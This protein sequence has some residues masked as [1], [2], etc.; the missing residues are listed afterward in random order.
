[1]KWNRYHIAYVLLA[2]L[3]V[4]ATASTPRGESAKGAAAVRNML[5]AIDVNHGGVCGT[6]TDSMRIQVV[7]VG[8]PTVPYL[9]AALKSNRREYNSSVTGDL[10]IICMRYFGGPHDEVVAQAEAWWRAHR[11]ETEQEWILEALGSGENGRMRRAQGRADRLSD[12]KSMASLEALLKSDNDSVVMSALQVLW[13]NLASDKVLEYVHSALQNGT[14][15]QRIIA[16]RFCPAEKAAE[17]SPEVARV[18]RTETDPEVLAAALGAAAAIGGRDCI[19]IVDQ[20]NAQPTSNA[21]TP[22]VIRAM[23]AFHGEEY[24]DSVLYYLKSPVAEEREAAVQVFSDCVPPAKAITPLLAMLNERPGRRVCSDAGRTFLALEAAACDP[25]ARPRLAE[26]IVKLIELTGI[27]DES[28]IGGLAGSAL[29]K[30]VEAQ[31]R[32]ENVPDGI[33]GT[34]NGPNDPSA[35]QP[36]WE[37]WWKEHGRALVAGKK[38]TE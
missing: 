13:H 38:L 36:I 29:R 16:L 6:S 23:S 12:P 33:R 1:M 20:M 28:H 3:A 14:S 35:L 22:Y 30:I 15:Q 31:F 4:V 18:L 10:E 27:Q 32:Y 37:K 25:S 9:I 21:L 19:A 34:Y 17:L 5:H 11:N 24:C 26:V 2:L 7:E 8:K